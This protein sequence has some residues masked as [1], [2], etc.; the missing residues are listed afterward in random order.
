MRVKS[1]AAECLRRIVLKNLNIDMAT[2]TA[3][4]IVGERNIVDAYKLI[5]ERASIKRQSGSFRI[6]EE[7][8]KQLM[9]LEIVSICSADG[10][11]SIDIKRIQETSEAALKEISKMKSELKE[12]DSVNARL[13][14]M[15]CSIETTSAKLRKTVKMVLNL[16]ISSKERI[17]LLRIRD[18]EKAELA[19]DELNLLYKSAILKLNDL[20]IDIDAQ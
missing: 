7:E 2:S 18:F 17:D 10:R 3:L 16:Y 12:E 20:N 14:K 5:M 13:N 8:Q 1:L 6:S 9:L 11:G 15:I 4:S 19:L